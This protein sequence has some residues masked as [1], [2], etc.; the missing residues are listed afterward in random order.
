MFSWLLHRYE[1]VL[2]CMLPI[3]TEREKSQ[4]PDQYYTTKL[5]NLHIG[6]GVTEYMKCAEEP[7]YLSTN[8]SIT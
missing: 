7:C 6:V 4:M 1:S 8:V 3:V 5:Q 2:L